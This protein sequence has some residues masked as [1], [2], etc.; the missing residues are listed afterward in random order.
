[1]DSRDYIC[2][3]TIN[4]AGDVPADFEPPPGVSDFVAGLFLPQSEPDWLRRRAYPARILL[5]THDALWVIPHSR[6]KE[7]KLLIP[8][9]DLESLDCGRIL[10]LGWIGLHWG[11]VQ[12]V[13]LYNRRCALTVERFLARLKA[14]WCTDEAG[15]A[16]IELR[17]HGD[18]GAA[19]N[20]KFEHALETEMIDDERPLIRFFHPSIRRVRRRRLLR[21]ETWSAGDL[22][23]LSRRRVLWITERRGTAYEPYGT[24]SHSA[25]LMAL[26]DVVYL[27]AEHGPQLRV[28]LRSGESWR[29]PLDDSHGSEAQSFADVIRKALSVSRGNEPLS[30]GQIQEHRPQMTPHPRAEPCGDDISPKSDLQAGKSIRRDQG[31]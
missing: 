5:L 27:P 1:M 7:Q 9:R 25:P 18:Y 20:E 22:I 15:L 12:Q 11:D 13:L 21:R 24:V 23:V 30:M 2:A 8:L 4:G 3:F 16:G 26:V 10:L 28:C 31:A 14:H 6:A 29:L 17:S 19:L